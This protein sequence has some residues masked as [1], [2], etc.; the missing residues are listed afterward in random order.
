MLLKIDFE[1][2]KTQQIVLASRPKG[3]PTVDNFRFEHIELQ[4]MQDE[5]MLLEGLYYSVDP[6][7]F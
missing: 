4:D 5:E 3:I 1:I 6:Y 7:I 2:M